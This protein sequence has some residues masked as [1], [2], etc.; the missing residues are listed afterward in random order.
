MF[1]IESGACSRLLFV[2]N[3]SLNANALSNKDKPADVAPATGFV[4]FIPL[5]AIFSPKPNNVCN[6]KFRLFAIK[7]SYESTASDSVVSIDPASPV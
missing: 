7:L 3:L 2:N 5:P 6:Q 1:L 4:L